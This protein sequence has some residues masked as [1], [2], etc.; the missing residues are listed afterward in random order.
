M[1]FLSIHIRIITYRKGFV[2]EN[3]PQKHDG[4]NECAYFVNECAHP[5]DLHNKHDRIKVTT[6][7]YFKNSG[8]QMRYL[9]FKS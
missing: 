2:K 3:T 9:L 5:I 6:E 1:A 7:D 4:D 8:P